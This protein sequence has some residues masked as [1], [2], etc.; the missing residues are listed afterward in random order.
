MYG[1]KGAHRFTGLDITSAKI[2]MDAGAA[3]RAENFDFDA[4][5]EVRAGYARLL[6]PDGATMKV[7]TAPSRVFA[8]E[9]NDNGVKL[10]VAHGV[11]FEAFDTGDTEW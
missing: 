3:Q 4:H 2:H 5:A 11:S 10:V 6:D 1:K 8:F 7:G 9:R